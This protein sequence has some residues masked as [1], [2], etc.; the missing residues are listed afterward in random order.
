MFKHK[1]ILFLLLTIFIVAPAYC[2]GISENHLRKIINGTVINVDAV[3]NVITIR[4]EDQKQMAFLV[5][6]KAS[7]TKE[8]HDVG[9]MDIRKT[10]PVT[11]QYYTSSPG[12]NT[13]TSI[14][15]NGTVASE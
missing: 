6:D 5:S 15:D 9:L 14:I 13:V 8:T 4:T 2:Q 11:M 3:G 12:K 1:S 7:V 10:D